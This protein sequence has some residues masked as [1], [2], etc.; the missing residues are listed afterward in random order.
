MT[1][2]LKNPSLF[3]PPLLFPLMNFTAF[4]PAGSRDC[5]TCLDSTS[6]AA[7]RP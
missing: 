1:I 7:T 3:L 6:K 4:W 2:L 5:V